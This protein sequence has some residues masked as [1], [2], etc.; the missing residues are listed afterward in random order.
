MV[1]GRGGDGGREGNGKETGGDK[2]GEVGKGGV[3][4]GT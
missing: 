3:E 4:M 2:K 1:T